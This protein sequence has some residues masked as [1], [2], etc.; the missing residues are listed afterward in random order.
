MKAHGISWLLA[1]LLCLG[2]GARAGN[3]VKLS[4]TEGK[5]EEEVTV[6]LSLEN[7]EGVAAMQVS[8][9]MDENLTLVEGSAQVG[10]RAS[11]H[12]VTAGV[13]DGVLNVMVYSIGMNTFSGNSGVVATWKMKLGNQPKTVALTPSKVTLTNANGSEVASTVL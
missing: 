2:M 1:L 9:P 3:V 12:S 5:P 4:S 10:S 13:K 8:I 7:S 6:S 11:G